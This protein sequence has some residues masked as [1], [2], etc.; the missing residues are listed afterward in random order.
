MVITRAPTRASVPDGASLS[1]VNPIWTP[2]V[3][4]GAP[5]CPKAAF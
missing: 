4:G 1:A 5:F 3:S 2:D